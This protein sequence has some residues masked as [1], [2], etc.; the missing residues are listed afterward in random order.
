MSMMGASALLALVVASQPNTA[1]Q[2]KVV[3]F[4]LKAPPELAGVAQRTTEQILL[5]LGKKTGITAIGEAEIQILVQHAEDKNAVEGCGEGEN[6][7]A[8]MSRTAEADKLLVGNIGKWGSGFLA[9]L[10]VTDAK[11]GTVEKGDSATADTEAELLDLVRKSVDRL[12]NIGG[13]ETRSEFSL[14]K[15]GGV[16]K[17]AV[18]NLAAYDTNPQLAD[19]LTQLLAIELKKVDGTSVISR[20]E[21]KAMLQYET[22]KQIAQC[23]SDVA[24]LVEIGGALGVEY[25]VS[26]GLGK[27]EDTYVIHLKLMDINKAEVVQRVSESFRGPETQLAQAIRFATRALL[28][29][30]ADGQGGVNLQASVE[31][32]EASIDGGDPIQIPKSV[33]SLPSGKHSLSVSAADHY[34]RFQEFYV[35]DGVSTKMRVE[36]EALPAAWYEQWWPWVLIGVA[37]AGGVTATV[38]VAG[39]EPET[40]DVGVTITKQ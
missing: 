15:G 33:E 40:G 7:L 28:N 17:M 3:V 10:S 9:T 21:I 5:H 35:E 25:L 19:N 26:G 31:P 13:A 20:D 32:A 8:A 12:L 38:L 27:L 39:S 11:K 22:Q 4:N 1:F 24:C 37:V 2:G 14:K 18:L 34:T 16:T 36:L 30:G 6:C 23:K 29:Q